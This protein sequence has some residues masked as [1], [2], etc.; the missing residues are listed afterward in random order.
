M[1]KNKRSIWF[2]VISLVLILACVL[3]M[4]AVLSEPVNDEKTDEENKDAS[5][6][7]D[8]V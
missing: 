4:F 1:E 6:S 7:K 5:D 2:S 8:F 3:G